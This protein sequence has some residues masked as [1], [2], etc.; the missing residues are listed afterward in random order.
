MDVQIEKSWKEALG[1]EFEKP[2]FATLVQELHRQ[3]QAGEVI[4]PPG[5][6]IFKAFELCPLGKVKVVILGQDPYH[7]YGQA[8]GLSFSVPQGVEAPPS[9]K[10]IFKE[11]ES[12]LGIRMSG[13]PDLRPWAEQGVLLLN[14]VLTVRAGQPASHSRIGWQTFTDAVI[15]TISD[16]CEGVVFLLWGNYARSKAVLVD[17]SRHHV[18]EAPHPSP[19]A[20]GAF[21]GCRHF[22]A[23]NEILAAEGKS[24]IDWEL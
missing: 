7:G 15:K 18:L 5:G 11:I 2:Y 23:T 21:F 14:S 9:L 10:N 20:R 22:S 12:D 1:A 3:K 19:L 24:P 17:K 16:R 6:Q 8:M 4:F 13:S